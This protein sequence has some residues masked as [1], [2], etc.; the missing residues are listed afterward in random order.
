M[1][2]FSAGYGNIVGNFVIKNLKKQ[3]EIEQNLLSAVC[4]VKNILQRSKC[5][6]PDKF[7]VGKLGAMDEKNI[8]EPLYIISKEAP[9]WGKSIKGSDELSYNPAFQFYTKNLTDEVLKRLIVP[10]AFINEVVE[11][12]SQYREEQVDFYIPD[13]KMIIEIDGSQ[14]RLNSQKYTDE[15]RD[16]L[17]YE[18]QIET[19]R[20]TTHDINMKTATLNRELE[21]ILDMCGINEKIN[22]Y[23]NAYQKQE[24]SEND[25][26]RI[27]YDIVMQFEILILRLIEEGY[28][29]FGNE[30]VDIRIKSKV[31]EI[32]KL[33]IIAYQNI[34]RWISQIARL[35]KTE[36]KYPKLHLLK[37]MAYDAINIDFSFDERYSDKEND[38]KIIYIRRDY[39]DE[40]NYFRVSCAETIS[41]DV[42]SKRDK[43]IME[44]ILYNLF[45]FENFREG[46]LEIIANCLSK[47]DTLGILPTGTGKSV[48]Y[49]VCVLLQPGISF[50]VCPLKALIDDQYESAKK[51]GISNI[52]VIHSGKD[53]KEKKQILDKFEDG[54]YLYLLISPERFQNAEFRIKLDKINVKRNFCIAVIDEVHCISEWGH[55]FRTSY[56]TLTDT[57]RKY[58]PASW[59][60]G[61]TATAPENVL[62]DIQ[63]SL[64]V[65]SEN[66]KTV[67]NLNRENLDF[68][69]INCL[70]SEKEHSLKKIVEKETSAKDKNC[71]IVF[72]VYATGKNGAEGVARQVIEDEIVPIFHGQM[73][74]RRQREVYKAF[75]N[76]KIPLLVAT[77]A[78]GMGID[79]EDITYTIHYNLPWSIESFY[80]EAGRAGRSRKEDANCYIIYSPEE[81]K[82]EE[83][84]RLFSLNV[85]HDEIIEISKKLENDLKRIFFLWLRNHKGSSYELMVVTKV[86][87]LL[88]SYNK[89]DITV[90]MLS[91][92]FRPEYRKNL[93]EIDLESAL[94]RLKLLGYVSDWTISGIGKLKQYNVLKHEIDESVVEKNVLKYI[95]SFEPEFSLKDD[96]RQGNKVYTDIYNDSRF[97]GVKKYGAILIKWIEDNVIY[98]RLM[99][100]KNMR[101]ACEKYAGKGNMLGFKKYIE[102][103]LKYTGEDIILSI[104]DSSQGTFQDWVNLFYNTKKYKDGTI[105]T[106]FK[107]KEEIKRMLTKTR[108]KI[109]HN[110]YNTGLNFV[111]AM[112]S[113]LSGEESSDVFERLDDALKQIENRENFDDMFLRILKIGAK[114]DKRSKNTLSEFLNKR[115]NKS[116]EIYEAFQDEFSLYLLLDGYNKILNST[117]E[118][119]K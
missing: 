22:N 29:I 82:N 40:R 99:A 57:I 61:L 94:Y 4:V 117:K 21:K 3:C 9:Y 25:K 55:D 101:E 14:H 6:R 60:L 77:K 37:T 79:K 18:Y 84:E 47:R 88:F 86:Y 10:E 105:E 63:I 19:V 104:L 44:E 12:Y 23:N 112:A 41:Y 74:Y 70:E 85:S 1:E 111:Y 2:K 115:Y 95:Q 58:C 31:D 24:Y 100:I 54:G 102:D 119:L 110:R 92:L 51:K 116:L 66:V 80:Q 28:I 67:S 97:S 7:L 50:V 45:G 73:S 76:G 103:Y 17:F 11:D 93:T 98:S 108:R 90:E 109:V 83:V 72:T 107:S 64:G 56:L 96:M 59:F 13:L 87:N 33:F 65:T 81:L 30:Q 53:A 38:E 69:I 20:L 78:F 48:C 118:K 91:K 106:K 43:D 26:L 68:H 39:F 5:I 114:A 75:M 16:R 46:Q 15:I 49:Q 89:N 42:H 113:I 34:K 36:F 32:E 8:E 27:K 52:N 71:G 62:T 35:E